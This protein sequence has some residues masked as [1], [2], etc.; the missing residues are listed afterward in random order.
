MTPAEKI[1]RIEKALRL[2]RDIFSWEDIRERAMDG[3]LQI[4]DNEHGVWVTE[5]IQTPQ[6]RYLNCH[7]VAGELPGVMA[8]QDG[9]IKHAA[10]SS[11]AFISAIARPGW[12]PHLETYGWQQDAIVIC[13]EV[14]NA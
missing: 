2:G 3:R 12:K 8:L 14:P 1:K 4:F 13:K 5:I 9:V 6:K 11:C 10:N 7:I